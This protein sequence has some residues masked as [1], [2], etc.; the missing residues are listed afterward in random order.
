MN[1]LGRCQLDVFFL[2][3]GHRNAA[4]LWI[5]LFLVLSNVDRAQVLSSE[6]PNCWIY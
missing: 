4:A 1:L 2:W 6:V 5:F 3:T